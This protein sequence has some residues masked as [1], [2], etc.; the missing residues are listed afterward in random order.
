M[1]KEYKRKEPIVRAMQW[2]GENTD[3]AIEFGGANDFGA[4][5]VRKGEGSANLLWVLPFDYED[6]A[7][8]GD[9]LV[10]ESGELKIFSEK[11]FNELFEE[12]KNAG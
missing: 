4:N 6:Y 5:N 12:V 11:R 10:W 3:E 1:I 7:E 8:P 9:Y 2:T